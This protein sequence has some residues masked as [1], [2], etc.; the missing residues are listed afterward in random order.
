[1]SGFI[2]QARSEAKPF[3]FML[4][5]V[6]ALGGFLFGYDTGVISG[7]LLFIKPSLHA[8]ALQQQP[9]IGSLLGGAT[10]GATAPGY[11]AEALLSRKWTK[12]L[13]GCIYVGAALWGAFAAG[14]DELVA[15]RLFHLPVLGGGT[16]AVLGRIG[17]LV[18]YAGVGV[19]AL[20]FFVTRVPRRNGRG[21]EEI[22]QQLQHKRHTKTGDRGDVPARGRHS[23]ASRDGRFAGESAL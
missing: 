14:P 22:E 2:H 8:S 15:S 5:L 16:R 20:I 18:L 12:V 4:A 13:S 23:P 6:A 3:L 1:M 21:L 19:L 7:A 11:L 9:I 17:T 10:L